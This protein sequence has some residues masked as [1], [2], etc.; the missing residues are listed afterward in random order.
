MTD[1]INQVKEEVTT[2]AKKVKSDVVDGETA[3]T[4]KSS[5]K[6]SEPKKEKSVT[7]SAET[8]ASKSDAKASEPKKEKSTAEAKPAKVKA[9]AAETKQEN[10]NMEVSKPAAVQKKTKA[11][12]NKKIKVKEPLMIDGRYIVETTKPLY[13]C[14]KN[15]GEMPYEISKRQLKV[16]LIRGTNGSLSIHLKT[17]K[18]LGLTKIG[19]FN[20]INDSKALQGMIFRVRH[21]VKVE[22]VK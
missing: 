18:A 1:K 11:P 6:T 9:V 4:V 19:S 5:P 10:I 7:A 3:K 13:N 15:K 14:H 8:K 21:L 2:K 12:V 16:T 22:E 17:V 20:I